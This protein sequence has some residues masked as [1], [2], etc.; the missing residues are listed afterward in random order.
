MRPSGARRQSN[1]KTVRNNRIT[2]QLAMDVGS[3]TSAFLIFMAGPDPV[4]KHLM[5]KSISPRAVFIAILSVVILGACKEGRD[6]APA[7]A[8][9]DSIMRFVP[10]DTPYLFATGTPLPDDMLDK[11][12]PKIDEMLKAYQVVFRE[13]FRS[14][15]A[16]NSGDM[17]EDDI[18]RFSA[19]VDELTSLLSIDGLREA[20]FERGSQMALFGNGLLPVLRIEVSDTK[21]FDAAIARMEK[22]AGESMSVAELDGNSYRYVGDDEM[23]L[24]IG[25]FDGSAVFSMIPGGFNDDQ[26]R[27]LLGLRLPEK[28][29]GETSTLTD[30]IS[31]YDYTDHY[32]G[33]I[34]ARQIA[35]TFID[36]PTGLNVALLASTEHDADEISDVCK[37]EIR[38][39][40][41]IAPRM[42]FGYGEVSLDALSGSMI[43]E[44]RKDIATGLSA[45]SAPVPGLGQDPGGLLSM[46]VSFN[47]LSLREFYEARLDAMEADP[48]ECEFFEEVQAG[49]AKGR[50]ALNQPMPPFVYGLRGFN[51]VVDDISGF[52]MAANK[53]P[54]NVEASVLVALDDAQTIVAMGAMFSPELAG[55]DLQPD[56]V[57]VK[58]DLPQLQV[59]A[60]VAYA[61]MLEDAV[62]ISVGSNAESRVKSVLNADSVQPSPMFSMTM[63]AGRYYALI[64]EGMMAQNPDDDDDTKKP[65]LSLASREAL[66]DAMIVVGDMYDRMAFDIRFTERGMELESRVT[67]KD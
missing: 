47:L 35:S 14:I 64:A 50:E 29:I 18:Q 56:G 25:A 2:R 59:V 23:T 37:A 30:I 62:A 3:V 15:V 13:V 5:F 22:A 66:R 38:E 51:A 19:V 4:R 20:G 55:M 53:P 17:S 41:E 60:D 28:S 67:L 49:V 6:V 36:S 52:D 24:V 21:K 40:V 65:E 1:S 31:T 7:M 39:V 42:V 63:D 46:G 27:Q 43:I 57:P 8:S 54:E 9:E 33:F 12:E 45:I 16:K 10:A 61:A 44:M 26:K 34:D 32:V 11:L 48:F 58:L